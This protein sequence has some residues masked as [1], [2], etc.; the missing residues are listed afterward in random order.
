MNFSQYVFR[1]RSYTPIPFIIVMLYYSQ[2]TI[3]SFIVG[4]VIAACGEFIRFWG[5]SI[6]GSETRTT[7]K[8]EGTILVT[9]GPYAYVRNPLYIGNIVM[10]VGFAIMSNVLVPYFQVAVCVFF[11]FQYYILVTLEEE[12]LLNKFGMEYEQ[13]TRRVP[14]FIP[15][16]VSK[17]TSV[18][19]QPSFDV[20]KGWK[21][22]SRTLQA[23]VLITFALFFLWKLRG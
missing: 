18:A 7:Q 9:S 16:F 4:F 19:V 1:F 17:K 22:E 5:V 23:F 10:Y 2:S 13:Y 21:S 11:A 20:H 12:F 8:L 15:L 6:V 14:R 3:F